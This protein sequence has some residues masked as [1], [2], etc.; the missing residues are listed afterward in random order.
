MV[1]VSVNSFPSAKHL[2]FNCSLVFSFY[3]TRPMFRL[4][5]STESDCFPFNE[6]PWN[7]FL[8][9]GVF[10]DNWCPC[11]FEKRDFIEWRVGRFGI[12]AVQVTERNNAGC[13]AGGELLSTNNVGTVYGLKMRWERHSWFFTTIVTGLF[14]AKIVFT[15]WGMTKLRLKLHLDTEQG[16]R[17]LHT[18]NIDRQR[19]SLA[20]NNNW[21][22]RACRIFY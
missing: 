12:P 2:V 7:N 15:S 16:H 13:Y 1:A 14:S 4:N 18:I 6:S 10:L 8:S 11:N 5:F 9:E 21:K 3:S 17:F 19:I 20:S 22:R